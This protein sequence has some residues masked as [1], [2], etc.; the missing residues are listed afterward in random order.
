MDPNRVIPKDSDTAGASPTIS[1]SHRQECVKTV[2]FPGFPR[3]WGGEGQAPIIR[4]PDSTDT[5]LSRPPRSQSQEEMGA[6]TGSRGP[7][8]SEMF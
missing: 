6:G 2:F 5:C 8:R 4:S 1:E 7:S 3:G